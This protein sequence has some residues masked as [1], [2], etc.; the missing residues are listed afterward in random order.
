MWED[1]RRR[2]AAWSRIVAYAW[3]LLMFGL[4]LS[5][6]LQ[7]SPTVDEDNHLTR[8]LA[9]LRTGNPRLSLHQQAYPW[10][11]EQEPDV[12]IGYSIHVYGVE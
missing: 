4:M 1:I 6:A 9:F 2:P 10:F 7:K 11:R 8:G 12:V 5:S 3:L